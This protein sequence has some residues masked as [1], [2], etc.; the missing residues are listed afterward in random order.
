[1]EGG[2]RLMT[3][4]GGRL[5]SGAGV[6]C[7]GTLAGLAGQAPPPAQRPP[8]LQTRRGYGQP[9]RV[10]RIRR[11]AGVTID[12]TRRCTVAGSYGQAGDPDYAIDRRRTGW[13]AVAERLGRPCAFGSRRLPNRGEGRRRARRPAHAG[14][15]SGDFVVAHFFDV[16]GPGATGDGFACGTTG[17]V[18]TSELGRTSPA[19]RMLPVSI[20]APLSLMTWK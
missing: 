2:S 4:P 19:R 7:A 13:I 9:R 16:G 8:T 18:V 12:G 3:A 10:P 15:V 11:G 1:M 14:P 5:N 20:V 17:C 6:K